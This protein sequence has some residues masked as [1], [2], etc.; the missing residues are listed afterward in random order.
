[1]KKFVFLIIVVVFF[2]LVHSYSQPISPLGKFTSKDRILICAPHPDDEVLGCGG[3]IQQ[4]IAQKSK[5]YVVFLTNG[6]HN[7]LEFKIFERKLILHP[8][9]YIQIGE[10]RRKESI[11]AEKI[12]G[13]PEKNLIFLGYPDAGTMLIWQHYWNVKK[14]YYD[15]LTKVNY[16]PYPQALSYGSPYAGESIV[17]DF[18]KVLKIVKPTKIFITNPVDTNSDHRAISNFLLVSLL[19]MK[20]QIHPDVYFYL[21]HYYK[22]PFAWPKPRRFAPDD[23]LYPPEVLLKTGHWVS[24]FFTPQQVQNQASAL[25]CFH[26]EMIGNK[27]FI[28][29]FAR[30]NEVFEK[31]HIPLVGKEG[32]TFLKT[33]ICYFNISQNSKSVIFNITFQQPVKDIYNLKM[34]LFGYNK[35]VSFSTMPKIQVEVNIHKVKSVRN[36]NIYIPADIIKYVKNPYGNKITLIVPK[37]LLG[38]PQ[39][40]FVGGESRLGELLIDSFPEKLF[41]LSSF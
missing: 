24:S 30:K 29:S 34:Y 5:V 23:T 38:N 9:N 22:W 25:M 2:N 37:Y 15:F 6:D 18:V 16:V 32:N 39:Y 36:G 19:E 35:K 27:G 8:Y 21:V 28:L 7:W 26:S 1:M 40:L 12:L 17:S 41:K 4:A 11:N 31:M 20:N 13:V 3:I 14:P 10:Q 33:R